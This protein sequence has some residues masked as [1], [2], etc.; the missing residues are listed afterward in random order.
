[1]PQNSTS[2][3]SSVGFP[4]SSAGKESAC[5]VGDWGSIPGSGRSPGGG[6]G[7][8]LQY[9]CLENSMDRGVWRAT[10]H[11]VAKSQ[12][13]PEWLTFS[14]STVLIAQSCPT[15]CNP[16]RLFYP[17]GFSRQEYWSGLPCPPSGDL[18]NPGIEP[19]PPFSQVNSLLSEPP[20]KHHF[21]PQRLINNFIERFFLWVCWYFLIIRFRLCI[22]SWETT[23][24]MICLSQITQV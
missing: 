20:G 7:N 14:P 10:V 11:Q 5:N 1:M 16:T 8:P 13:Q 4:G 15:L 9:S 6:N 18:P 12:T 23:Y 17:W 2:R 24:M 22:P 19:W 21:P 3:P